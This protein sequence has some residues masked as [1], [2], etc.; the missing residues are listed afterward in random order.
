M[1]RVGLAVYLAFLVVLRPASMRADEAE[2]NRLFVE[3]VKLWKRAQELP[4]AERWD[5][6]RQIQENLETIVEKHPDSSLAVKLVIGEK[7]GPID[8]E[9][10]E[11]VLREYA[12]ERRAEAVAIEA[13]VREAFRDR[14][15]KMPFW[16]RKDESLPWASYAFSGR[17]VPPDDRFE[18]GYGY[19]GPTDLGRFARGEFGNPALSGRCLPPRMLIIDGPEMALVFDHTGRARGAQRQD[20]MCA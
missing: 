12:P 3:A 13:A 16:C 20:A 18:G 8:R 2:A 4:V 9:Y 19:A 14:S 10:L 1:C 5:L 6:Y 15:R 7:P 11:H 17:I